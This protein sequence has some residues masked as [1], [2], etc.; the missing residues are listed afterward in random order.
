MIKQFLSGHIDAVERFLMT[1]VAWAALTTVFTFG[2]F[3]Y[4]LPIIVHEL[5]GGTILN[6]VLTTLNFTITIIGFIVGD[7]SRYSLEQWLNYESI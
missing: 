2:M 5:G 6:V 4:A 7:G 1:C 3:P